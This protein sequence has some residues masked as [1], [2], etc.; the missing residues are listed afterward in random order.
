MFKPAL[1]VSRGQVLFRDTF[2]QYGALTTHIQALTLKIFGEYLINLKILTSLFYSLISLVLY[3]ILKIFLPR[4]IVFIGLITWI[5]NAPYYLLHF[6]IWSSVYALFFQLVAILLF[7]KGLK[8]NSKLLFFAGGIFTSLTFLSRQPVGAFMFISI[9]LY[10]VY[11]FFTDKSKNIFSFMLSYTIGNIFI[12]LP[13]LIN[14]YLNLALIDWWKQ[15][16]IFSFNWINVTT[17]IHK[18]FNTLYFCFFPPSNS[19]LSVWILIPL[20]SIIVFIS[21]FKNKYYSLLFF[22]GM[23]SWIQYYPNTNPDHTY[24]GSTPMLPLLY[25]FIYQLVINIFKKFNYRKKHINLISI[26]IILLIFTPDIIYNINSAAKKINTKYYFIDK[27][28]VLKSIRFSKNELEYYK[29]IFLEIENYFISEPKGNVVS[30][31]KDALYLTFDERIKNPFKTYVYWYA[32]TDY[33]YPKSLKLVEKY[34]T[35]YKPLVI[36]RQE[37]IPTKYC[38]IKHLN[39]NNYL[40]AYIS[41]SCQ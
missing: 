14:L 12:C 3:L 18:N 10:F 27:P 24:W 13:F 29:N 8:N 30:L 31:S 39:Y 16:I 11:L 19:P 20:A 5:L 38:L 23:S 28:S 40:P 25:I 33:I 37:N 15:S 35:N 32:Q 1:D 26:I 2:T 9:Y 7:I 41:R 17:S 6:Q 4:S 36:S 34:I 22:I 21:K